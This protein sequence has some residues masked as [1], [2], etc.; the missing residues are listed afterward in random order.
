M[1]DYPKKIQSYCKRCG[2]ER[3]HEKREVRGSVVIYRCSHCHMT[4]DVPRDKKEEDE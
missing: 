2:R 4:K 1:P 3:A